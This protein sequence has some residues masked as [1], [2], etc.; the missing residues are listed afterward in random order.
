M[1]DKT[2]DNLKIALLARMNV[3]VVRLFVFNGRKTGYSLN[4]NSLCGLKKLLK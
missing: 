3:L 2:T 4:E 1:E